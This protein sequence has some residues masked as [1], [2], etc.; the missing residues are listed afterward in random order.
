MPFQQALLSWYA[1]HGRKL[2][3]RETRDPYAIL[4]SEVMLQQ[5]QVDRVIPKYAGW[6]A[7]FPDWRALAAASRADVLKLW[8]GLGYNSRAVRLHALSKL[9]VEE[10]GGKL[11]P[12]EEKL[13]KLPGIGPYTAGALMAFAF[14]E[15]GRCVDVNIERVIRRVK[16]PISKNNKK[17]R[18]KTKKREERNIT[19]KEIEEEFLG[20]F[21]P[22]KATK[23]ANALMDLG[24]MVCTA[25]KPT[26]DACPV[27]DYCKSRG[28][29]P[30]E[31]ALRAKKRQGTFL[32]S[33]RW[34]RGQILKSLNQGVTDRHALF[35]H[36]GAEGKDAFD[37]ALVQLKKEGLVT[38]KQRLRL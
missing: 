6:L 13:R 17:S 31:E 15:P 22:G 10:F 1:R 30:D 5:T 36:I 14:N 27:Y 23:Y 11:P 19:R 20:S 34:W 24:A 32:H 25:T 3:W 29:R 26:C 18:K 8:S 28:E 9:L 33:N 4:V 37:N 16:H 12:E 38:G 2:P 21:P 35:A 7:A